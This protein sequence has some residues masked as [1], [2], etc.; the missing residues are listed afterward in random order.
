MIGTKFCVR[1]FP[2]WEARRFHK[3]DMCACEFET[4]CLFSDPDE[5]HYPAGLVNPKEKTQL[6]KKYNGW[7]KTQQGAKYNQ[8]ACAN[9]NDCPNTL[10]VEGARSRTRLTLKAF[11]EKQSQ[12][13]AIEA[14]AMELCKEPTT[15][16]MMR[17]ALGEIVKLLEAPTSHKRPDTTLNLVHGIARKALRDG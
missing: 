12:I 1:K 14:R 4:G 3:E 13:E 15:L 5:K 8:C 6:C 17:R 10:L 9:E 11:A 16:L 2:D 7:I